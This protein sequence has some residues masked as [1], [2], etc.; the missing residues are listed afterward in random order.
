[1]PLG[2]T[3]ATRVCFIGDSFAIHFGRYCSAHAIVTGSF[4]LDSISLS[5]MARGGAQLSFARD[6]S[7][8]GTPHYE[9]HLWQS[10]AHI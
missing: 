7:E 6:A 10:A 1:M 9:Q 2:C 3:S 8:G 5:V 4:D